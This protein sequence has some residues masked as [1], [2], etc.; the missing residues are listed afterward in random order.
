LS[1]AE[2]TGATYEDESIGELEATLK[3]TYG[4]G[5]AEELVAIEELET[6]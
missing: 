1:I 6:A 2:E 5:L 4:E 3:V